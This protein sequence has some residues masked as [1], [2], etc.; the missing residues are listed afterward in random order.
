MGGGT[1]EATTGKPIRVPEPQ[2]QKKNRNTALALTNSQSK[3]RNRDQGVS[4]SLEAAVTQQQNSRRRIVIQNHDEKRESKNYS[5]TTKNETPQIINIVSSAGYHEI[6]QDLT[7]ELNSRN[8][9]DEPPK[10]M[11]SH[12]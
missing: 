2:I 7:K 11:N 8:R 3:E 4:D 1:F 5:K 9:K 6:N 12:D 10:N